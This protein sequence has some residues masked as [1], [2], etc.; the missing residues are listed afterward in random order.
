VKRDQLILVRHG[1]T[2]HNVAG[3]TQGW[4][5]SALS[6]RGERQV[7]GLAERL[8]SYRPDAIYCSPLQRARATAAAIAATTGLEVQTL[9]ELREMNY[10]GWEGRSFLDVRRDDPDLYRRW[11]GEP[12]CPCPD[13]ESH[14]DVRQRIERA[15]QLI[16]AERPVVVAHGTAIR[17]AATALMGVP[18]MSSRH[19]A[20][21][22]AAL[23]VFL[24]R[25]ERWV[26]KRWN[27]TT[28]CLEG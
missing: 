20:Q 6:E 3:I 1:E 7:R 10:G 27:D 18:V 24:W 28:H 9:D 11:I 13:G 25:G 23:N 19:F 4:G 21:D 14:N 5:D 17:I 26:L 16:E 2:M 15:F 8:V 22:N 12:D